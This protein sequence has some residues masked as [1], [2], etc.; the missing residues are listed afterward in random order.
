MTEDEADELMKCFGKQSFAGHNE[1]SK[2]IRNRGNAL[3]PYKCPYCGK[4]HLG[5]P[6][7]NKGKR[8]KK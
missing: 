4:W 2:A 1:A 3:V 6:R 5:T 8:R 7:R